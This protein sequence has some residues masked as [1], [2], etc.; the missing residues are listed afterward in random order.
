[1]V[2]IINLTHL[3]IC[4]IQLAVIEELQVIFFLFLIHQQDHVQGHSIIKKSVGTTFSLLSAIIH[5]TTEHRDRFTDQL[6]SQRL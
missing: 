2:T 1:M 3:H 6:I 5:L 4:L